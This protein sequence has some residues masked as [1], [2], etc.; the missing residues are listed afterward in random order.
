MFCQLRWGRSSLARA[1]LPEL[2]NTAWG[3]CS[4]VAPG[5][6]MTRSDIL[7]GATCP[8]RGGKVEPPLPPVSPVRCPGPIAVSGVG[9]SAPVTVVPAGCPGPV[10][11]GPRAPLATGFGAC[12]GLRGPSG[13]HEAS[14]QREVDDPDVGPG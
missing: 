5:N 1:A 7:M 6:R 2:D 3:S 4:Q 11:Y 10:G 12:Q 13:P 14:Q 9:R 8:R